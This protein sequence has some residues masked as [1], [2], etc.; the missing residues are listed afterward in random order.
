[1]PFDIDG[2]RKKFNSEERNL[3]RK[4]FKKGESYLKK[5]KCFSDIDGMLIFVMNI[6]VFFLDLLILYRFS[7]I[8]FD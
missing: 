6:S 7:F 3:I 5:V 1:M 4:L 8:T 2:C